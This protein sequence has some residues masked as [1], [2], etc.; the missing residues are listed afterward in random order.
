[1]H[2]PVSGDGRQFNFKPHEGSSARS[3]KEIRCHKCKASAPKISN[4]ETKTHCSIFMKTEPTASENSTD[5]EQT[6]KGAE[7]LLHNS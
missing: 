7:W 5:L 6:E 1:M 4:P 2:G 3:R